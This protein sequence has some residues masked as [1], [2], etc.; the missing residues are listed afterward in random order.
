[1]VEAAQREREIL[2]VQREDRVARGTCREELSQQAGEAFSPD[3][4]R[5]V[6]HHDRRLCAFQFRDG[7]Q[8]DSEVELPDRFAQPV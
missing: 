2:I 4:P 8:K 7:H 1:M 3:D 5:P 6:A